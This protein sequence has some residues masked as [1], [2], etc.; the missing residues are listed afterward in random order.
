MTEQPIS[1]YGKNGDILMMDAIGDV[2]CPVE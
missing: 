2:E 1:L